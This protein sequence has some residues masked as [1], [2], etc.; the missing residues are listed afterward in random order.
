M[1][2]TAILENWQFLKKLNIYL[3]YDS[4]ISFLILKKNENTSH[5]DMYSNDHSSFIHNSQRLETTHQ[6][7][8]RKT[9]VCLDGDILLNNKKE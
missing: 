8:N 2:P 3:P 6:P 5:I 7:G 1:Y 4:A 9:V